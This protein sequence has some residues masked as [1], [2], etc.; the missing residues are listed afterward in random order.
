[1]IQRYIPLKRE[2]RLQ[3]L[4]WFVNFF[5]NCQSYFREPFDEKLRGFTDWEVHI[6]A[7]R[8]AVSRRRTLTGKCIYERDALLGRGG[9]HWL[10]SAYNYERDAL[11]CSGGEHWQCLTICVTVCDAYLRLLQLIFH[12]NSYSINFKCLQATDELCDWHMFKSPQRTAC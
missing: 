5:M 1:M 12:R 10:R 2:V 7:W 9:G 8:T 11:L 3:G 6:W 4:F